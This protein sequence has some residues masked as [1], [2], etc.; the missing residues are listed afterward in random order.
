MAIN[1]RDRYAQVH[2]YLFFS[3]TG[4]VLDSVT[5]LYHHFRLCSV[6]FIS[7]FIP[8]QRC[9]AASDMSDYCWSNADVQRP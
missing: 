8:R 1:L 5:V 2:W 7:L 3:P 4:R 6:K 9:T